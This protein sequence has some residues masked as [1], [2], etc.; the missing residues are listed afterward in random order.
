MGERVAYSTD[1][2]R[3]NRRR[4]KGIPTYAFWALVLDPRTKTKVSKILHENEITTLWLDI[5]TAIRLLLQREA[6]TTVAPE[7]NE[8]EHQHVEVPRRKKQKP[9]FLAKMEEEFDA[10]PS[11]PTIAQVIDAEITAF[12]AEKGQPMFNQDNGYNNPLDWWRIKENKYPNVWKLAR[13]VLAI[14]ATSAPSERV[15]SAAANIVN[16]KRK[17]TTD[18]LIF[19]QEQ[20]FCRVELGSQRILTFGS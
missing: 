1:V 6:R 7:E 2:I 16:K 17:R 11:E 18:L 19:L 5:T 12:Q 13:C 14:P 10:T 9:S 8:Q 15:F 3:S 20:R 4:Q